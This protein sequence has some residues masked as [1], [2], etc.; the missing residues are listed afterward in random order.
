M[1]TV[2]ERYLTPEEY[3]KIERAAETKSEYYAGEMFAM[4]GAKRAHIVITGNIAAELHGLF[5]DRKCEV[6]A[7]DM[8]VKVNATG[9]YTYPDVSAVCE[10]PEFED[11]E[12]DTLVNPQVI[13][14][15]L[16]PSTE[17]YDRGKKFEHY[18]KINSLTDY[19]IVS[20]DHVHLEHWKATD[21]TWKLL[22]ELGSIDD[23]LCIE[24]IDCRIPL[25]AVYH[26]VHFS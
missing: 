7:S 1:S 15:V 26:K 5:Q 16:S 18:R 6:Y 9:L 13:F 21:G 2:P 23:C 12:V 11:A 8:R 24:S 19:V 25:T 3:L 22:H 10:E 20:Q 17:G 4:S 14:E